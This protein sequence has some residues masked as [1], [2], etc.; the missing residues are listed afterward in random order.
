MKRLCLLRHAKSDWSDTGLADFDR[1][2]NERGKRAATFMAEFISGSDYRP[3]HI[4]CSA[5][6]RA[7][8]TLD[9]LNVRLRYDVPVDLTRKLYHAMP[10]AFFS[11]ARSLPESAGTALVIA[12]N[13]GL[14][15]FAQALCRDGSHALAR[16]M[17]E[18]YPTAGFA[19]IGF[20]IASWADLQ[21][22]VG[23]PLFFGR[24][25]LLMN[26]AKSA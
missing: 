18:G 25:K 2:L 22:R 16:D 19:V 15:L 8:A 11:A 20:D 1:P 24:P 17:A 13:P 6:V 3:E 12:H 9:P 21:P 5:A 10:E 4:V 7:K 26:E 23:E 14:E